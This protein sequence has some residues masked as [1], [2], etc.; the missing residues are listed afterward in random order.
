VKTRAPYEYDLAISAVVYDTLLVRD[1]MALGASRLSKPPGWTGAPVIA[2]TNGASPLDDD[3]SRVALV[4]AQRVWGVDAITAVDAEVL[5]DRSRRSPRS[6]V[7]VSLDGA[8]IPPWMLPV[9]QCDLAT[10]GVDGVADFV[11]EVIAD[12]GGNIKPVPTGA[13]AVTEPARRWPDPPIPY[14]GQT[15]AHGGLRREL[16]LIVTELERRVDTDDGGVDKVLEV[17]ALPNRTV[18]RIDD[19][20][21]SFSW[22]PARSGAVADGRLMVIEWSGMVSGSRRGAATLKAAHPV[23]ECVYVAEAVDPD[24]WCWRAEGP[25]GR[26]SS[27]VHLVGEWIAAAS[28][29]ARQ[30]QPLNG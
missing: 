18:A 27:T 16:D 3:V 24:H 30:I 1:L 4:L 10:L 11:L 2:S 12:A 21:V 7:A 20:G 5:R 13:V 23:R 15:R 29:T 17:Q 26:A 8:P 28:M 19:V 9:R 22:V 14:L 6:V 25:H